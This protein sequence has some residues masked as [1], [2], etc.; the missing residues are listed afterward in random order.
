MLDLSST[1]LSRLVGDL[2]APRA[3]VIADLTGEFMMAPR[4]ATR[5]ATTQETERAT[6]PGST[7]PADRPPTGHNL[8]Q[9]VAKVSSVPDRRVLPSGDEVVSFGVSV[10]RDEGGVDAVPV[11][12]GP[13]PPTGRRPVAGQVGRRLLARAEA[14]E[15]GTWVAIEGRLRRRWWAA[16]GARRSRVEVAATSIEPAP[17]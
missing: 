16:A 4:H 9:L 1:A 5:E 10:P 17:R 2:S 14:L 12:V 15:V 6:T 3:T 11:Q 13:A 8:V 7:G